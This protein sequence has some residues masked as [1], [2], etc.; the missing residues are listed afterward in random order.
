[1]PCTC[2]ALAVRPTVRGPT[3]ADEDEQRHQ[4]WSEIE[5]TIMMLEQQKQKVLSGGPSQQQ[6]QDMLARLARNIDT[7]RAAIAS[8]QSIEQSRLR[9]GYGWF[10]GGNFGV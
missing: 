6:A 2:P 7:H 5:N 9:V 1:M 10:Y 3:D 8:I 4:A